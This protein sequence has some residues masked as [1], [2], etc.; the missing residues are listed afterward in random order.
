MELKAEGLSTGY[1][2]KVCL[3]DVSFSLGEG[4]V[5]AVLGPN[6]SGK[7]TLFKAIMR[8]LP[9]L[10]GSLA[11]DRRDATAMP[12]REFASQVSYIPQQHVPAFPYTVREMVLMGRSGHIGAFSSPR[13]ADHA[14]VDDALRLLRMERLA[15]RRYTEIS[16]GERRLA[17]IARAICQDARLLVMDEPSS[18]LDYANQQLVQDTVARLQER[19]YGIIL[20]THAPEYPYSVATTALLL[21]GGRVVAQ[22]PP[23]E[24]LTA[25]TLTEAF[26]VP[27]DVVSVRDSGG[28]ERRLCLPI[29]RR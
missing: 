7:T 28:S 29:Q 13:K 15:D 2:G 22:G 19:G 9:L 11:L 23:A 26:G 5:L 8:F 4:E 18:D 1:G 21:Q 10:G 25:A 12:L 3:R 14:A 20:S 17:L 24:S 27:M 16:G 6:G